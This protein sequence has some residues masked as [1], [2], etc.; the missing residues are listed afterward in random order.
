M[1]LLKIDFNYNYLFYFAV[2]GNY[3]KTRWI[4]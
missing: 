1:I 2:N 4:L 3:K